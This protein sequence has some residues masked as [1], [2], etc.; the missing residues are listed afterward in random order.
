[1]KLMHVFK[2]IAGALRQR[3][4]LEKRVLVVL[5]RLNTTNVIIGM[6][7]AYL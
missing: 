7:V 6:K 3:S 5:S 1:M 4:D 2:V